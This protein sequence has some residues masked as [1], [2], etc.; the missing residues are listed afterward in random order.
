[1]VSVRIGRGHYVLPSVHPKEV[2]VEI[3][4]DCNLNCEFCFRKSWSEVPGEMSLQ[5][6][7]RILDQLEGMGAEF[8]WLSGWGEPTYHRNFL[9]ILEMT[10]RRFRTGILTNGTMLDKYAREIVS[11]GVEKVVISVDSLDP[12]KYES[13]RVGSSL[14][15]L[16]HSIKTL[17][18]EK[19]KRR[20]AYPSIWF[21][22]VLM[23][24]NLEELPEEIGKASE[25]GA[26]GLILSNLIPTKEELAD[27]VLYGRIPDPRVKRVLHMAR[28]R[29]I[30]SRIRLVEP[31]FEYRTDRFCPFVFRDQLAIN[32]HGEVSPCLFALHSYVAWIDGRRKKVNKITFGNV[33]ERPL[34]EIWWDRRYAEFRARVELLQFPSCNDCPFEEF[35]DMAS[36]NELDC[37]GNSPSC[38]ACPY[39]RRVVQC[40]RTDVMEMLMV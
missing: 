1:M 6:Y 32:R 12:N 29:A 10:S 17:R 5:L 25:M 30:N 14:K 2:H 26:V 35:C 37:W 8:V 19:L 39:Y 7:S 34:N 31:E 18:E 40:P 15:E 28:G 11:Y 27:Q 9:E 24:S 21:I 3:T 38:A 20:S 16:A 22:K 23:K 33:A 36:S 13:I 4:S